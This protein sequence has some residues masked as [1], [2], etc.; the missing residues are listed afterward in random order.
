MGDEDSAQLELQ[1]E[2]RRLRQTVAD[3]TTAL[4]LAEGRAPPTP[5]VATE[6]SAEERL[7]SAEALLDAIFEHS[8]YS[9]W[10]ADASG[11][12]LRMNQACRD[13]LHVTDDELVGKYNLLEDNI[14]E[15]EGKLP[16]VKRAFEH[17][18]PVRFALRYDS[19]QL[20]SVPLRERAVVVLDVTISPVLDSQNRVVQAIVQHNDISTRTRAEAAL[21]DNLEETT[22]LMKNMTNAFVL[23]ETILD[24]R[25]ALVD[26]RF[27]YFN[28]AY[29]GV[30][31]VT[32]DEVRGRLVRDVWPGTEQSWYHVYGE[33]A[34]TGQPKSFEMY[35]AP[36]HG[37]YACN[38]YRPWDTADRICVVFEDVTERRRAEES[39]R[40]TNR[41]L[42]MIDDCDQ[43]LIRAT[44][45]NELLAT[46]CRTVVE[47]GGYR[48]AWV[49][50]AQEDERQSVRPLASAGYVA[51]YLE[52][53]QSSWA[54]S[55]R[56]VGPVGTAIRTGRACRVQRVA[57]DPRFA[58]WR[59]AATERG[60]AAVCSLPL[61]IAGRTA[62]ALS[63]YPSTPDAFGDE[64]VALLSGLA[65]NIAFGMHV[66][67]TREERTRAEEAL[68]AS[69]ERFKRLVGNSND[70][71]VVTDERGVLTSISGPVE[72]MLGYR[73]EE[74]IGR[75][76]F[77]LMH[78]D[79]V[80]GPRRIFESGIAEPNATG[81]FEYPLPTQE[82]HLGFPGGRRDEPASRSDCEGGRRGRSGPL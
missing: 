16:L 17:G 57:D 75:C 43:A 14:V 55:E 12:M 37:L 44:A 9:T 72:K 50:Y 70:L 10:V 82:R 74:L 22:W 51:G 60:Y 56:G 29:A 76:A 58:A 8:A 46:I 25:G 79:D 26:F 67:R 36:T 63:V 34:R 77:D 54:D 30:S 64:E 27:V 40:F 48:M 23:W 1:E 19:A 66:L 80:D 49:G 65:D 41:Q 33:V 28:D 24:E 52:A 2:L 6:T 78:P 69:E 68:R 32:L 15:A 31:G 35:H 11:T 5:H 42:R 38:A 7:R 59:A 39:L 20:R 61:T 47:E 71:I 21:R 45:E 73:P 13:L 3:L 18:E 4:R 53:A 81:R 62:G